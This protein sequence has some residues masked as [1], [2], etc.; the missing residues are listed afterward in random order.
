MLILFRSVLGKKLHNKVTVLCPQIMPFCR[1]VLVA[2]DARPNIKIKAISHKQFVEF[3][4]THDVPGKPNI[5]QV[6][7]DQR[8]KVGALKLVNRWKSDLFFSSGELCEGVW[9]QSW[10]EL[11]GAGGEGD[12]QNTQVTGE[13]IIY[14]INMAFYDTQCNL[15]LNIKI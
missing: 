6:S 9:V 15:S 4:G 2:I 11:Y 10:R 12:L 14:S 7:F 1:Q 13:S 5:E 3:V 8:I